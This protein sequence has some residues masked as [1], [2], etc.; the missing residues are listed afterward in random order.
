[1]P[2]S[3][4]PCRPKKMPK[5]YE[6]CGSSNL[7]RAVQYERGMQDRKGAFAHG[8]SKYVLYSV[9]PNLVIQTKSALCKNPK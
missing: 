1:M 6:I 3:V 8:G 2:N 7:L 4:T 9:G 5:M